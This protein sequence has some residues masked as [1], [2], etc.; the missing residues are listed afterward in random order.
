MMSMKGFFHFYIMKINS[1]SLF[2]F[3]WL[4]VLI[5]CRLS[6]CHVLSVLIYDESIVDGKSKPVLYYDK[7]KHLP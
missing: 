4:R 5:F 6:H 2:P 1:G 3:H 7:S